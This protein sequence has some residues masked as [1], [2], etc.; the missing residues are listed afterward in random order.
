MIVKMKLAGEQ[1]K[2]Q[3]IDEQDP[4]AR[5]APHQMFSVV[6]GPEALSTGSRFR[7]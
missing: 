4:K 5:L 2:R 6:H 7:T 1:A 3:Q